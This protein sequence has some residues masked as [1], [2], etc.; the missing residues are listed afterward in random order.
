MIT[1]SPRLSR[2]GKAAALAA[3][4]LAAAWLLPPV[5][6]RSRG[7]CPVRP[8]PVA[9]A[10]AVPSFSRK[11]GFACSQCHTAYP[12][13]NDF[14][15][16]FKMSGYTTGDADAVM[17]SKDGALQIE[18]LFPWGAVIRS[19]PF[20]NSRGSV[21]NAGTWNG[22]SDGS[23]G[24]KMQV[25]NDVDMFVAGGDASRKVSWFGELDASAPSNF[26]PGLGDLQL[27]YHP[28]PYW[29]VLLARKNFYGLDPYQTISGAEQPMIA[30]RAVDGL[31][32]DQTGLSGNI[33]TEQSQTMAGYGSIGGKETGE[34]F[35]MA[36]VSAGNNDNQGK[37]RKNANVRL[38]Y[39]TLKGV[40]LGGFGTFGRE[41]PSNIPATSAGNQNSST[42]GVWV[43]FVKAG[44]DLLAE[45][46]PVVGRGAFLYSY[47]SDPGSVGAGLT[48]S[49]FRDRAAY[50]ELAYVYKRNGQDAPY[51]MPMVRENWYTTYNGTRQFNYVSTQLAHYFNEN[52]K[53]FVEYSFDTKT[54]QQSVPA[55]VR[56]PRGNRATVQ[57][58]VGF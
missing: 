14:G 38:A 2:Q 33:L 31:Q 51:L 8:G 18:K 25:I 55:D 10:S 49:K 21:A 9:D 22:G 41:Q 12:M 13:L 26:T 37:S 30:N 40:V 57:L 43:N 46:G 15:R 20:D 52:V 54:D 4:L 27:G 16:R 56:V 28:S 42:P 19:R 47:E 24:D 7:V 39:D 35:Y 23:T 29:N 44:V 32:A 50:A 34:L 58:E 53:A 45:F 17:T 6:R 11:Y 1:E 36:G 5:V 3:V 48:G